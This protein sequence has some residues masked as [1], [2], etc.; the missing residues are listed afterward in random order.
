MEG[1]ILFAKDLMIPMRDGV[2][3]AA[4]VYCPAVDGVPLS[5]RL[6]IL[7]HQTPYNR[8]VSGLISFHCA[9]LI[10]S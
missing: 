3:L 4:D 9:I 8:E 5:A 2:K 10:S 7:L 1:V 6:P